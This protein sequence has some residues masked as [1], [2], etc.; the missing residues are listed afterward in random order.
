MRGV[1]RDQD[2]TDF[3]LNELDP[4]DRAYVEGMIAISPECRHDVQSLLEISRMLGE[5]F[6]QADQESEAAGLSLSEA[7][8]ACLLNGPKRSVIGRVAVRFAA[9]LVISALAGYSLLFIWG[10]RSGDRGVMA[11]AVAE[12]QGLVSDAV[13]SVGEVDWHETLRTLSDEPNPEKWIAGP[14]AISTTTVV[15]TPTWEFGSEEV[16]GMDTGDVDPVAE[17]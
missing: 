8:R 15:S 6:D 2:L 14:A 10:G 7:Q 4:R 9:V 5:G 3:A 12:A 13:H 17:M 1:I 16:A 11:S